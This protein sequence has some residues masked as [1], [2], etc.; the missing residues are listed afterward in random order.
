[1]G[2]KTAPIGLPEQ[3]PRG[4]GEATV[5]A[6]SSPGPGSIHITV[7]LSADN[8][9]LEGH[10]P[11]RPVLPGV[12]QLRWA[13]T[14]A[15]HL[16]PQLGEVGAVSNLK[17]QKPVLPPAA[18]RLELA[19]EPGSGRVDFSWHCEDQRCALGRVSFL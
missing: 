9:W 4:P 15:K 6:V 19:H 11:G 3:W 16:W 12:V 5:S 2:E 14:L 8:P 10:F 1:M 7:E 18:L 13:I 17:F